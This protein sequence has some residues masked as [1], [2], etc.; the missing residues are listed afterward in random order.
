MARAGPFDV[1]LPLTGSPGIECRT[2][3]A[4]GDYLVIVGFAAPVTLAS[5]TVSAG[6]GSVVN[7]SQRQLR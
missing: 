2:G 7:A 6:I 4:N 3:G 1:P 5:A